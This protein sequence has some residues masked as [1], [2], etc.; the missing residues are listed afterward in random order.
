MIIL[1]YFCTIAADISGLSSTVQYS[2]TALWRTKIAYNIPHNISIRPWIHTYA[3]TAEI[4][5]GETGGH[6][7][8]STNWIKLLA[9]QIAGDLNARARHFPAWF[10]ERWGTWG[11]DLITT[12]TL[13]AR[14]GTATRSAYHIPHKYGARTKRSFTERSRKTTIL[15]FLILVQKRSENVHKWMVIQYR[16]I[17]NRVVGITFF[18]C[19][20]H[21]PKKSG[22]SFV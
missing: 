14:S 5:L 2:V 6:N 9:R 20:R 21:W 19:Q 3:M 7:G 4:A 18:L 16:A 10:L 12:G 15:T 22:Y 13:S 17:M 1:L 11:E 8:I